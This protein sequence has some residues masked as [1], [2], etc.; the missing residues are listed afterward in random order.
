M[1]LKY[2]HFIAIVVQCAC[3][4]EVAKTITPS[5]YIHRE[6]YSQMLPPLL[7]VNYSLSVVYKKYWN[8][9]FNNPLE[10]VVPFLLQRWMLSINHL[11]YV[12]KNQIIIIPSDLEANQRV[13]LV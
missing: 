4:V 3:I 6:D 10:P 7:V 13:A 2:V 12:K 5:R 11:E 8:F 9:C 1:L